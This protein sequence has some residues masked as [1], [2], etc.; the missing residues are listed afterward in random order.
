MNSDYVHGYQPQENNRLHEQA[1]SLSTH[2]H[3]KACYPIDSKILE[4]GCGVGAQSAILAKNNP[5]SHITAVDISQRSIDQ[6]KRLIAERQINNVMFKQEDLLNLSFEAESFD[7]IFGTFVL[8][9][10]PQPVEALAALKQ[11][12]RP[13]GTITI[14]E[15][16]HG[17]THFYPDSDSAH[18][19]I[20]CQVELQKRAGGNANIGRELYPLLRQAGFNNIKVSP[21]VIYI[22][23][24]N[25][26]QKNGFV[27]TIFTPMIDGV[28]DAAIAANII[29]PA[30]FDQGIKD[31]YRTSEPDGVFNLTFYT[32]TAQV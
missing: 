24:N 11:Q 18:Q 19:A 9:H 7:H 21:I 32:V 6:A 3:A 5:Q 13:G 26:Q 1:V 27:D 17:S 28:R 12:L 2:L 29:D 23:G 31:L 20:Q 10:L 25:P 22:D 4:M 15:G 30:T 14:T 16:D 8:E